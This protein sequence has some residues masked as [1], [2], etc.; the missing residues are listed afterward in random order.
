MVKAEDARENVLE[1]LKANDIDDR[2]REAFLGCSEAVQDAILRKGDLSD[3][4]NASSALMAR[5]GDAKRQPLYYDDDSDDD[6]PRPTADP[7]QVEAFI[8]DNKLDDRAS[9]ALRQAAPEVQHIVLHRGGV[10]DAHNPS[11]AVQSRLREAERGGRIHSTAGLR[12]AVE[13]FILTS[14]IDERAAEALRTA[15]PHAQQYVIGRGDVSNLANPSSSIMGRLKDAQKGGGAGGKGSFNNNP[16]AAFASMMGFD[17]GPY[18]KGAGKQR[19]GPRPK[20]PTGKG[21]TTDIEEFITNNGLDERCAAALRECDPKVQLAIMDRGDCED[22]KN[23]NSAVMGRIKDESRRN[24]R[25]DCTEEDVANFIKENELD[26]KASEALL[27]CTLAI[28][29]RVLGRGPLMNAKNP[30][31]AV[32]GRIK[33]AHQDEGSEKYGGGLVSRR[34]VKEYCRE[35]NVDERATD[36]L[37]T[38]TPEI[39]AWVLQQGGVMDCRNPSTALMGRIKQGREATKGGKGGGGK[40]KAATMGA[41]MGTMMAAMMGS[42]GGGGFGPK[43]GKGAY[44]GGGGFGGKGKGGKG[45]ARMFCMMNGIDDKATDDFLNSDFQVQRMVMD[46]GDLSSSRNP[47]SAL[48]GR[49]RDAKNDLAK[50]KGRG[51][52]PY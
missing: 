35:N 23:P 29:A 26:E 51:G 19:S 39:Q 31:S 27:A 25:E 43:G 5:I 4:R 24:K 42:G 10:S 40:D 3:A 47:S 48:I 20:P 12:K 45:E 38:T 33:D 50:G 34:D 17:M 14:N 6:A 15:S 37:L 36:A 16:M 44:G 22:C 7:E 8:Q 49:I 32:L 18:G 21:T 13:D 52:R 1:F 28:Q 41:M 2:A 30:S 46:R 9:E 11:S